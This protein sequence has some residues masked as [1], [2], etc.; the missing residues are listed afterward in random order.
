MGLAQSA[1]VGLGG[2]VYRSLV[3]SASDAILCVDVEQR[4]HVWNAAA[5]EMFGYSA[6]EMV[7]E[8]LSR[9]LPAVVRA[10]H[11][12]LIRGFAEGTADRAE[13]GVGQ[14]L[15]A[16]RRGGDLFPVEIRLA[17]IPS[18][19][20][21][22]FMASVRDI[23]RRIE[24]ENARY[25]DQEFFAMLASNSFDGASVVDREG[26]IMHVQPALEWYDPGT[27]IEGWCHCDDLSAVRQSLDEVARYGDGAS[28][29]VTYRYRTAGGYRWSES[30]LTNRLN[31][32]S[33][34]GI[35]I[36]A[37]DITLRVEAD[38]VSQAQSE[39]YEA[40]ALNT[41]D[42]V[43]VLDADGLFRFVQPSADGYDSSYLTGLPSSDLVHPDDVEAWKE[44]L[45]DLVDRGSG[46][47]AQVSV[48]GRYPDGYR[49]LDSHLRNMLD[50][51]AVR[52]VVATGR[53]ITEEHLIG[54]EL[55][56]FKETL[57]Q[58][59]DCVFMFDAESLQFTYVNQGAIAQLGYDRAELLRLHPY[60][61]KPEFP[62]A[63]FRDMIAPLLTGERGQ[64]RLETFHRHKDG[65]RVPVDV[66]LQYVTSADHP[67]RFIAV[68]RDVTDRHEFEVRLQH[69]ATHDALTGLPNR[70]LL[71][72]RLDHA[73]ARAARHGGAVSV[74]FLDLDRFKLINDTSG[75][76]VGDQV[77]VAV[78]ERLRTVVRKGDTLARHGGDEF[79]VLVENNAAETDG[80]SL[81]AGRIRDVLQ[82]PVRLGD[83]W[84]HT[85][86]SIGTA[87]STDGDHDA[88]TLLS[89]AD[90]AM[91][92][93]KNAGRD[94]IES[95]DSSL[96]ARLQ[97]QVET[98]TELRTAIHGDELR[99]HY[100]PI[101]DVASA[102]IKGFEALV[103]WQHP[104]RGLLLPAEFIPIAEDAGLIGAIDLWV[105]QRSAEQALIWDDTGADELWVS[106]N[107]SANDLVD[108]DIANH[109]ADIIRATGIDPSRIHIEVTESALI[110]HPTLAS[111]AL[112]EIRQLGTK[113]AL[114]DFGTGYS[115]L[116]QL[117][118]MP[119]THIKIDRS[120]INGLG[121]NPTDTAI[122][123]STIRLAHD[124]GLTV[125]AEGVE[126]AEQLAFLRIYD[127]HFAQGYYFGRPEPVERLEPAATA[128]AVGVPVF[129]AD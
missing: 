21:P 79:V 87:R 39:W 32:A 68:V 92:Q 42:A 33:V 104:N 40:L 86:A 72:D 3:E 2:D 30:R 89:N 31:S 14:D 9:L 25:S 83:S 82:E 106:V 58:T 52:G 13:M 61:I 8:S 48:R 80:V 45:E 113:I 4:I 114:D 63:K 97:H 105:L 102:T 128:V 71:F 96:R 7:G 26:T 12:E 111:A 10:G 38:K 88:A 15:S 117:Q 98:E 123:E 62:E 6:E 60:D 5:A 107:L 73:L 76:G 36:N 27:P 75:H 67:A 44:A 11:D 95:F 116:T 103:R 109:V 64:V 112:H 101:V 47:T 35:V 110:E 84:F 17:R 127:C 20:G 77:L 46:A 124:L 22:L 94:C 51:P 49:W 118:T 70:E 18:D 90:A 55:R 119:L 50:H 28:V 65:H 24:A 115:S 91:Y 125:V 56:Q 66:S 41:S 108:P 122:V 16:M 74:L 69:Q 100:Q 53:D 81:L 54:E 34:G 37:R 29:E 126:T 121:T 1:V 120:F 99:V 78:A 43:A 85:T 19:A 129:G 23:S 57:D 59:L 93:A